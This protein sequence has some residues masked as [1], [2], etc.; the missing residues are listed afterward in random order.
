L[1]PTAQNEKREQASRKAFS[2]ALS[3]AERAETDADLADGRLKCSSSGGKRLSA[4][5]QQVVAYVRSIPTDFG[6]AASIGG[7][8]HVILV[9]NHWYT[10]IKNDAD[11]ILGV[12]LC[13]VLLAFC[14]V[15]LMR[16]S[17]HTGTVAN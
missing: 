1:T 9:G 5:A 2:D 6:T 4:F 3:A 8:H 13:V 16:N 10:A 12:I 7:M 15:W 14:A 11:A 17:R